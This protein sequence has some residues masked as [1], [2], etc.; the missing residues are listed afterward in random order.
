M[1]EGTCP[2]GPFPPEV[3]TQCRLLEPGC[4]VKA[5]GSPGCCGS[6]SRSA[7]CPSSWH[8]SGL[9]PWLILCS[10]VHSGSSQLIS[11]CSHPVSEVRE[12]SSVQSNSGKKK[13]QQFLT[14]SFI[15]PLHSWKHQHQSEQRARAG[16]EIH[17]HGEAAP[18]QDLV[19]KSVAFDIVAS[20]TFAACPHLEGTARQELRWLQL[21]YNSKQILLQLFSVSCRKRCRHHHPEASLL[22]SCQL[23]AGCVVGA[24]LLWD[25]KTCAWSLFLLLS[26]PNPYS[27]D[28]NMLC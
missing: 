26:P 25:Y 22:S 16:A 10:A 19:A 20:A 6:S 9:V 27:K 13:P 2:A 18:Q 1:R 28:Q 11:L 12:L 7:H 24:F 8:T 14:W 5:A 21:R 15:A 17:V 4:R 3:P 23:S